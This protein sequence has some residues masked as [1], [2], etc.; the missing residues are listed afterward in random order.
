MGVVAVQDALSIG[1]FAVQ[2]TVE[3]FGEQAYVLESA[4]NTE[5]VTIFGP[6]H[7]DI[8][9]PLIDERAEYWQDRIRKETRS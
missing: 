3:R 5:A 8:A 4:S 1:T 9:G 7:R 6:L 2:W